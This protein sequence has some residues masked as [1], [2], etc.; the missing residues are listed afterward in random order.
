MCTL[1]L[2]VTGVL[3]Y[4]ADCPVQC[5]PFSGSC[6]MCCVIISDV[7]IGGGCGVIGD[8]VEASRS[9]HARNFMKV[10]HVAED[11]ASH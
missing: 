11:L 9:Q 6:T 5:G 2:L 4:D 1:D 8:G 3:I 7:V 10:G